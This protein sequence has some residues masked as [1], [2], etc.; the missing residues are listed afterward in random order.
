VELTLAFAALSSHKQVP[1]CTTPRDFAPRSFIH[2]NQ[3]KMG[4]R[5]DLA[6]LAA[7]KELELLLLGLRVSDPTEM[8]LQ[9]KA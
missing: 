3:Q 5:R 7:P 1:L 9:S 2:L 4:R 6:V 8:G